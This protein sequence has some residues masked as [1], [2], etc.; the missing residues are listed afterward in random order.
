M[1]STAVVLAALVFAQSSTLS[2]S[3]SDPTSTSTSS[4]SSSPSSN[5][6]VNVIPL[7]SIAV[8]PL[9]F[10][11]R[12]WSEP[13]VP[14]VFLNKFQSQQ[15]VASQPHFQV[16]DEELAKD[17][18]GTEPEIVLLISEPG[19]AF[20]HEAPVYFKDGVRQ[21]SIENKD[22]SSNSLPFPLTKY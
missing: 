14:E 10:Q 4:N 7:K 16:F 22:F 17:I 21:R 20:A 8:Q 18:L 9:P 1:L 11:S 3:A 6:T 15:Q 5:K 12:N 13:Y 2:S 19:Y